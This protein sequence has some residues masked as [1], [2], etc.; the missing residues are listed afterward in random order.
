MFFL[1]SV[2]ES[3]N[4]SSNVLVT[5]LVVVHNALVGGEDDETELSGGEDG[6][7]EV[8]EVLELEVETG[9][10]DS[11]FVESSVKFDNDFAGSGVIDDSELVDVS[12]LL[13][14]AEELD[15][16]LGDRSQ[17]NLYNV[18]IE[19]RVCHVEER[20]KESDFRIH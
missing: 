8:L 11:A 3:E 7:G 4:L 6:G 5:G 1:V 16:D 14:D 13:H 20:V 17:N 15:E 10:D 19:I 2:E 12:V 9:G 18:R